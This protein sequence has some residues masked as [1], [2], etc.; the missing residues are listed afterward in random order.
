MVQDVRAYEVGERVEADAA[1]RTAVQREHAAQI[2]RCLVH[3]PVVLVGEVQWEAGGWEHRT[4]HAE[5]AHDAAQ[6]RDRKARAL[7]R[8]QSNGVYA[9]VH[10]VIAVVHVVVVGAA[11]AVGVLRRLDEADGEAAR[12]EDDG[13]FDAGLVEEVGPVLA[14]AGALLA[15][16]R[17]LSTEPSALALEEVVDAVQCR[18]RAVLCGHLSGGNCLD[19]VVDVRAEFAVRLDQVAVRVQQP[20]L[21]AGH[22]SPPLLPAGG[23]LTPTVRARA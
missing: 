18:E 4:R 13:L 7:H 9:R 6:L 14:G 19:G 17:A 12:G 3:R 1:V 20:D 22:G 21:R 15:G 23:M 10:L 16:H 2:G 11:E 5:V 8:Y